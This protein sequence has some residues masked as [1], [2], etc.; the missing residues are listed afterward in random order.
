MS[1]IHEVPAKERDGGNF[2]LEESYVEGGTVHLEPNRLV[3]DSFSTSRTPVVATFCS[4]DAARHPALLGAILEI[5]ALAYGRA[6]TEADLSHLTG[7]VAHL[8][9]ALG[10]SSEAVQQ[11]LAVEIER[12]L[13]GLVSKVEEVV[14]PDGLIGRLLDPNCPSGLSI[15]VVEA[16]RSATGAEREHLA[17]LLDPRSPVSPLAV[18]GDRLKGVQDGL[19]Q[20][21]VDLVAERAATAARETEAER[22]T[23]K[24]RAYEVDL[25]VA[26]RTIGKSFGDIVEPTGDT[27]EVDGRKLGDYIVIVPADGS[28]RETAFAVEAKASRCPLGELRRQ[29]AGARQRR[30]AA[31]GLGV[32]SQDG[33][34]PTGSAPLTQVG[35]VDFACLYDPRS[36][37]LQGLQFGYRLA[38]ITA[39]A[40]E[41]R[42]VGGDL[43]KEAFAADLAEAGSRLASLSGL[44]RELT[45]VANGLTSGIEAIKVRLGEHTR[46]LA[47]ILERMEQRLADPAERSSSAA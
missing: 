23:Q 27:A 37:D 10:Q 36:G 30:G 38:R 20:L 24:G 42:Q 7:E 22:G 39:L 5:G 29:L 17:A 18:L 33:Y 3:I 28:V 9:A 26:L 32:Y 47:G 44:R 31:A 46:E 15:A 14:G 43:D 13:L 40:A 16:V 8:E 41:A 34:M 19:A 21:R 25:L 35:P 6:G 12:G 11:R 1:T 4:E 45:K 2:H